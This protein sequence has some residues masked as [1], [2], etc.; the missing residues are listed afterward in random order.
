MPLSAQT[1]KTIFWKAIEYAIMVGVMAGSFWGII[2]PKVRESMREEIKAYHEND[3]EGFRSTLG[4]KLGVDSDDVPTYLASWINNHKETLKKI[5]NFTE[6]ILPHIEQELEAIRPRIEIRNNKKFWV[7]DDGEAYRVH[8]TN[9]TDWYV[10]GQG[11]KL[12]TYTNKP[13]GE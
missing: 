7:A 1:K 3:P 2:L 12:L 4:R 10:N 9:G 13:Y 8:R 11:R 6:V 5:D